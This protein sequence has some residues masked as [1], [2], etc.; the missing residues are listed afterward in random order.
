MGSKP[1]LGN[2]KPRRQARLS[3]LLESA[4]PLA[5]VPD[6]NHTSAHRAARTP[7][8]VPTPATAKPPIRVALIQPIQR[9]RA[10]LKTLLEKTGRFQVVAAYSNAT[11]ALKGL[12][13]LNPA[14]ALLNPDLPDLSGPEC[15]AELHTLLPALRVVIRG[16]HSDPANILRN[17]HAG[18]RG[19]VCLDSPPEELCRVLAEDGSD[20]IHLCQK[21][22]QIL[23]AATTQPSAAKAP[24]EK[25]TPRQKQ[26]LALTAQGLSVKEIADALGITRDGVHWHLR[27]LLKHHKIGSRH[28]LVAKLHSLGQI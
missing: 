25:L 21:A 3:A 14:V 22:Q 24:Q 11:K 17:I 23:D 7:Q 15:I 16:A 5:G 6:S 18:A 2:A 12:P 27:P 4:G 8:N 9:S 26:V 28:A 19:F 1:K 10:R 20:A 13:A